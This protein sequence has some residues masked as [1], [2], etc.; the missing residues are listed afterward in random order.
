M[1]SIGLVIPKV[2]FLSILRKE[3]KRFFTANQWPHMV[4]SVVKNKYSS[5]TEPAENIIKIECAVQEIQPFQCCSK[6]YNT[7]EIEYSYWL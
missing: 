5:V 2:D 1:S 6:Q 7:K 3:K 4:K